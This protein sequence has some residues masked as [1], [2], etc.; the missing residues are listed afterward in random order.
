MKPNT[1]LLIVPIDF[2]I[3][4]VY[5]F[6]CENCMSRKLAFEQ[7]AHFLLVS[8]QDIRKGIALKYT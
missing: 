1:L 4:L 7:L 5:N 8:Y 6:K 3:D 2:K